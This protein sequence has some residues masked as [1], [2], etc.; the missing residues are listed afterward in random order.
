MKPISE[1]LRTPFPTALLELPQWCLWRKRNIKG[2]VKK[3]PVSPV[4]LKP[5]SITDAGNLT[6]YSTASKAINKADGIGFAFTADDDIVGIDLDACRDPKTGAVEP[7]AEDILSRFDSWQEV[8]Q[9]GQGFHIICRGSFPGGLRRGKIEVYA[10]GRYFALT[11]NVHRDSGVKDCQEAIDQ[12]TGTLVSKRPGPAA[13]SPKS[14]VGCALLSQLNRSAK[15]RDLL[16]GQWEGHYDS[17]SQADM[18]LTCMI[19]RKTGDR[20]EIEGLLDQSALTKRAKWNRADY[21]NETI[22]KALAFVDGP[23]LVKTPSQPA[24]DSGTPE[25]YFY[26]QNKFFIRN[27]RRN[28]IEVDK[29]TVGTLLAS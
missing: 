29:G 20:G 11:G 21:R 14:Q 2:K 18:A 26:P 28:F 25:V 23:K 9:S 1:Q 16:A 13:E 5:I 8:S 12:L 6:D 24:E 27:D 17:A 19:A 7:W 10:Q 22:S 4:T 3:I 15:F